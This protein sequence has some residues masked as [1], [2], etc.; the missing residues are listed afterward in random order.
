MIRVLHELGSLDG[1]GVARLLYDYYTHTDRT[2]VHFDF[3]IYNYYENGIL[4]KPLIDLGCKV[5]KVPKIQD[6]RKAFRKGID[7][8]LKDNRYDIVH[9]HRGPQSFYVLSAAKKY[10]VKVR[11]AHSHLAYKPESLSR[12]IKEKIL[13][14]M[15]KYLATQ[16]FA[17][18]EDAGKSMWGK[19]KPFFIMKNAIDLRKFSFS[20]EKRLEKRKQIGVSSEDEFV[21]GI[22]GRM[23]DQKNYSFLMSVIKELKSKNSNFSLVTVGRG[24]MENRIK[25]LSN[26]YDITDK[27][28]F[29]GIRNDVS[30]LLN[31]FDGFVLPSK[32]EGLPVVLI[33]AQAN[34]LT[35]L[36]SDCVTK[37]MSVTDLITFLPIDDESAWVNRMQQMIGQKEQ[38][39]RS[40]YAQLMKEAG[41]SIEEEADKLCE[42]YRELLGGT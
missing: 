5:Y 16:L 20:E 7:R 2:N 38:K 30:E 28:R 10:G 9:S 24:S 42:K 22:V 35:E 36:V 32:Y 15:D 1:G 37:E 29:L 34:G 25:Q 27:V 23:E 11:I 8:V 13:I 14:I 39:N 26:D 6:G 12:K 19:N 33:E 31:A 21:F 41:Y 40:Q 18:G 17:C 3:L 4:E